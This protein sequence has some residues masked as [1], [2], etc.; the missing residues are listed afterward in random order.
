MREGRGGRGEKEKEKEGKREGEGE[1]EGEANAGEFSEEKTKEAVWVLIY[2][3]RVL[4][5]EPRYPDDYEY[6]EQL[7]KLGENANKCFHDA[8]GREEQG[9]GRQVGARRGE[10][11]VR[12]CLCTLFREKGV[13]CEVICGQKKPRGFFSAIFS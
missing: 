3:T 1:G 13:G 5:Q 9:K 10:G 2:H 4:L 8:G 12:G 7:K 11:G 6:Q